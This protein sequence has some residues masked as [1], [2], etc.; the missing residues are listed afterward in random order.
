LAILYPAVRAALLAIPI[1]L[2]I[3]FNLIRVGSVLFVLLAV[4]GV[5]WRSRSAGWRRGTSGNHNRSI[6]CA[7]CIQNSRPE[8][9]GGTGI[10]SRNGSPLQII[11]AG[12]G[13]AAI[14]TLP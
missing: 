7:E 11:H 3:G 5:F 8:S 14:T 10:T 13:T 4:A 6:C 1:P 2:L 9:R 12:V